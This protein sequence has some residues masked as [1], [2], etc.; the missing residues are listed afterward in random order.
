MNSKKQSRSKTK[1]SKTAVTRPVSRSTRNNRNGKA[2]LDRKMWYSSTPLTETAS[3]PRLARSFLGF[4][5][6]TFHA[7]TSFAKFAKLREAELQLHAQRCS[8]HLLS[9]QSASHERNNKIGSFLPATAETNQT[10]LQTADAGK[11]ALFTRQRYIQA[12]A[13]RW[14][15]MDYAK[16][17]SSPTTIVTYSHSSTDIKQAPLIYQN[18]FGDVK[19]PDWPPQSA[20]KLFAKPQPTIVETA[21][22]NSAWKKNTKF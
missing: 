19:K 5:L 4:C 1:L 9:Q 21:Y 16:P 22:V 3:K 11:N 20:R 15:T 10:V 7:T 13:M 6:N 8:H 17:S 14:C 2:E 12:T 18:T